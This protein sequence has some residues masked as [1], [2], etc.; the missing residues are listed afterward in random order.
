[1]ATPSGWWRRHG[2]GHRCGRGG[3]GADPPGGP[4]AAGHRRPRRQRPSDRVD[5]AGALLVASVAEL[6]TLVNVNGLLSWHVAIGA[7]LVPPAL[8]KTTSTGWRTARYYTGHPLV[9]GGWSAALADAAARS[10]RR[11]L[12]T[13]ARGG[14]GQRGRQLGHRPPLAPRTDAVEQ[15]SDHVERVARPVR[16]VAGWRALVRRRRCRRR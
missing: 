2:R 16:A 9:P 13:G 10:A 7:L 12:D 15:S 11:G 5:R 3:G 4:S 8:M 6:L 1:V 14:A